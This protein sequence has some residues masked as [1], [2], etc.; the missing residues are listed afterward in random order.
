[1][2]EV[3]F[4]ISPR[5]DL[6]AVENKHISTILDNPEAFG[7]ENKEALMDLYRKH[8]EKFRMEGKAREEIMNKVTND[9]WI[10]IRK[11]PSFW[12]IEAT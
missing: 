11:N 1:M 4:F 3:A 8:G 9:G 5:G 12:S 10:R 6:I 2:N 7:F